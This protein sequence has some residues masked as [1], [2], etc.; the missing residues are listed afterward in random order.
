M[1][2][3]QINDVSDFDNPRRP[4]E[5]AVKYGA[6]A[7]AAITILSLL[8]WGGAKGLPGVWG[9][10]I[11]AAL[12]GGFVLITALSVLFTAH[13]TPTTTLSVVFGGWLLKIVVLIIVLALIRDL[14]F[15]DHL[16]LFITVV[17]AL[18]ATLGTEVWGVMTARVSYID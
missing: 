13:S 17:C 15:Y 7:L 4:L 6:W 12:G 11:G 5:R 1:N 3:A 9:V 18:I 16:A 14:D 10:L 2:D 8:M